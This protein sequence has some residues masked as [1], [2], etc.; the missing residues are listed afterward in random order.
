MIEAKI[1]AIQLH[2]KENIR[3]SKKIPV[4]SNV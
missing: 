4:D 1:R 2:S 3:K